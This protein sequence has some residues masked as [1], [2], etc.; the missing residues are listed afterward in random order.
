MGIGESDY[1]FSKKQEKKLVS[2]NCSVN[3]DRWPRSE[4][5]PWTLC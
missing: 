3:E 4:Y 5:Q 1:A 2:A